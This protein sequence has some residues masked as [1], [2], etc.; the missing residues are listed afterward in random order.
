MKWL[1]S[2]TSPQGC[3]TLSMGI[4]PISKKNTCDMSRT[5]PEPYFHSTNGPLQNW[6]FW[7]ILNQVNRISKSDF[8]PFQNLVGEHSIAGVPV[9]LYNLTKSVPDPCRFKQV[10]AWHGPWYVNM[11]NATKETFHQES[12]K[13]NQQYQSIEYCLFHS[14]KGFHLE[15]KGLNPLPFWF[16]IT[17]NYT[18]LLCVN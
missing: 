13:Y 5:S 1:V 4:V 12:I 6:N 3:G 18:V 8:R 14:E 2:V 10:F 7:C 16:K 17:I 11:N 15:Y 9:S